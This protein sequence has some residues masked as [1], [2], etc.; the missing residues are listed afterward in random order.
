MDLLTIP[1][2][3]EHWDS[4]HFISLGYH[5]ERALVINTLLIPEVLD[6]GGTSWHAYMIHNTV[7]QVIFKGFLFTDNLSF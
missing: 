2:E 1:E 5:L 7:K 6:T 3:D 4:S